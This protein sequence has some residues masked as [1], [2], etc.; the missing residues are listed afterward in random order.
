MNEKEKI[1]ERES[2]EKEEVIVEQIG[3]I[4]FG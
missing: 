3:L 2:E 4:Y 1:D